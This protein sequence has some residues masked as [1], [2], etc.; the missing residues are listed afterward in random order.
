[1]V[2]RLSFPWWK[3]DSP[4]RWRMGSAWCVGEVLR[5]FETSVID[6][7]GELMALHRGG[8]SGVVALGRGL[9][10]IHSGPGGSYGLGSAVQGDVVPSSGIGCWHNGGGGRLT[11]GQ[12][13]V[14]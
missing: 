4:E 11:A 10:A 1:V 8:V 6:R 7:D 3:P 5:S 14:G 9:L 2:E 12:A 13:T